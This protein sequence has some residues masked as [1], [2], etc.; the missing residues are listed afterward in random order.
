[1][2]QNTLDIRSAPQIV[3]GKILCCHSAS[4]QPGAKS[5]TSQ[6]NISFFFR[7]SGVGRVGLASPCDLQVNMSY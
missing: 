2:L 4:L 1:M 6:L 7:G 3:V 5:D